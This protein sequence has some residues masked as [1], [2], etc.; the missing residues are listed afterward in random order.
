[1]A[2]DIRQLF[3]E[4]ERSLVPLATAALFP[5]DLR[6]IRIGSLTAHFRNVTVIAYPMS[7]DHPIQNLV[8]GLTTVAS[9]RALNLQACACCMRMCCCTANIMRG[10][11]GI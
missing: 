3:D 4:N 2:G 7:L 10:G 1:L 6:R 8:R 9:V 11:P 5:R